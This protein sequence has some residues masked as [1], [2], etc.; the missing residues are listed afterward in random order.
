[1]DSDTSGI[2]FRLDDQGAHID[3]PTRPVH[4]EIDADDVGLAGEEPLAEALGRRLTQLFGRE[5]QDDEGIFDL[6]AESQGRVVA[7]LQLSP[8]DDDAA[9]VLLGE[10]GAS[11][12]ER[13]LVEALTE[14]LA[15]G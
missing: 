6:A 4:V 5:V 2:R 15:R 9:L 1:M 3:G 8:A 13:T 14:A 11:T 7:A 10:R 12:D